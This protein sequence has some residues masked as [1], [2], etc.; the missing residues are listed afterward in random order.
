[1]RV[2]AQTSRADPES[3]A[4]ARGRRQTNH[5][6]KASGSTAATTLTPHWS[7]VARRSNRRPRK[8]RTT[9]RRFPGNE[10]IPNPIRNTTI[11]PGPG[12]GPSRNDTRISTHPMTF[13]RTNPKYSAKNAGRPGRPSVR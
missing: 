8:I 3:R 12:I 10:T 11:P 13:F 2:R 5:A 6:M 9:N 1:M 4:T 7:V